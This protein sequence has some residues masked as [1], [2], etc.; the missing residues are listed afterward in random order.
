MRG[1]VQQVGLLTGLDRNG[2]E[3]RRIEL[4][5]KSWCCV[6]SV[7]YMYL[8]I[9]LSD[10]LHLSPLGIDSIIWCQFLCSSNEPACLC[11]VVM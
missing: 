1:F 9:Y 4:A 3:W 8:S 6:F 7:V 2:M 10:V 11:V 5:K